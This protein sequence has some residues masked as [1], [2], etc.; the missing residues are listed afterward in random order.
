MD[1]KGKLEK[2]KKSEFHYFE[3]HYEEMMKQM[4]EDQKNES[5]D[6]RE[7]WDQDFRETMET[8]LL[9]KEDKQIRRRN[10]RLS[11]AAAAVLC[12]IFMMNDSV[13]T[14]YGGSFARVFKQTFNFGEK[15]Y[16]DRYQCSGRR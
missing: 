16:N 5:F 11:V 1:K 4:E 8:T 12:I 9:E 2:T 3:K 7:S 10:K 14:V 15:Q 6:I 13:Q